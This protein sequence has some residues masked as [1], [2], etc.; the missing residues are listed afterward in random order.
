MY[1]VK[2]ENMNLIVVESPTKARTLSRFLGP[3]YQVEA[4]MGH[5]RDLPEDRLGVDVEKDFEPEYV[6]SKGKKES[7]DRIKKAAQKADKIYLASDPDREGEAIAY[8]VGYLIS[9]SSKSLV[10]SSKLNRITFHEITKQAI[11]EALKK[12]GKINMDLVEA[13][14]ARRILDRLV[15]YKLSPLLWVKIRKGLSAGR[16]QSV[17]VRLI[18]ER[19]KEIEKF[20]PVEFWEIQVLLEK[21][22]NSSESY[23]AKLV[24]KNDDKISL[25]N[26]E[27][28]DN[29]LQELKQSTF[30]VFSVE[31]KEQKRNPAPPFSTSTLQQA[32]AGRLGW[33]SKRTMNIAQDLYEN[34]YITYHRTDSTNLSTESIKAARNYIQNNFGNLYLPSEPRV[35]ETKSRNA[36]EAHEAIR[37]TD[38]SSQ[39]LGDN[40]DQQ[41]LYGLIWKRFLACQMNPMVLELTLITTKAEG[42]INNYFFESR[43]E[44]VI[45]DGWRKLYD[46]IE[47]DEEEISSGLP[48]LS[49]GEK[50]KAKQFKPEQKFT[51]PPPRYNEA[52]LIKTLEELGIGRPSTYA[53]IISTI[54]DRNYVEKKEKLFIPTSLG[55]AVTEFLM[56]NFPNILDYKFT[57]KMEDDLDLISNGEKQRVPILKEFYLPFA[58]KLKAVGK[59]AKRVPVRTEATGEKCPKCIEGNVVVRLGRFGKFLSCDRFPDCDFRA[60][61]IEKV[62]NLKCPKCGGSIVYKKTKRGKGFYGCFNY[63]NC[64]FASWHKP[65]AENPPELQTV[66]TG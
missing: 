59:S 4:T 34:G 60:P 66:K 54:Q 53:P 43:G 48:Q 12:P 56:L 19:E 21:L 45:F 57:A 30:S 42:K 25:G 24:R 36:Q 11:D 40:I 31:T 3:D 29:I 15:G 44:K 27:D 61:Y 39:Q 49:E 41:R 47:E 22:V 26:K 46:K 28:T 65:A 63:P 13:Q 33:T 10:P 23:R 18:V 62:G 55:F 6:L 5:V 64:D 58:K 17:T 2:N 14:T 1:R 35:Y 38:V 8:H 20:I 51:T 37:P 50:L 16:V 32:A 9:E 52:S 7:T